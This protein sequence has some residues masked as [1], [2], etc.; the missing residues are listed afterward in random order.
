MEI[1]LDPNELGAL[2]ELHRYS[3]P[4]HFVLPS[5]F[6]IPISLDRIPRRCVQP[7]HTSCDPPSSLVA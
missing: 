4:P 3:V 5:L 1:E 2:A 7:T 6:S